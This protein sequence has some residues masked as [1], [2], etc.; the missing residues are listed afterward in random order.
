[1]T[2]L[3]P[4]DSADPRLR[5]HVADAMHWGLVSCPADA[6]L[7]IVATLM[8]EERVHCVVILDSVSDEAALWGVVTDLDLI[9]AASVR[10]LAAQQAGGTA[11]RPAVTIGPDQSLDVAARLMTRA[12]IAHLVVLDPVSGRPIGVLSTLDLAEILSST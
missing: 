3:W 6:S 8:S 2:A 1:M 12:G 11:L 5:L 7:E 4:L 9:A 10:P